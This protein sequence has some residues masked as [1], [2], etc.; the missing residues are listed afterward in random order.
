MMTFDFDEW[1]ELAKHD[2]EAFEARRRA[3][4]AEAINSAPETSR[5]RL[6][7][8]QWRLDQE[9]RGNTAPLVV[10]QRLFRRMWE[11][12]YGPDGLLENLDKLRG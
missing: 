2:P 7:A 5:E 1:A 12:V 8:L 3:A 11:R 9:R 10:A 6:A 4:V